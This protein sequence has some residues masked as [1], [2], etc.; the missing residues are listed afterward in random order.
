MSGGSC[1]AA[2]M[3]AAPSLRPQGL[4]IGRNRRSRMDA[5]LG[6]ADDHHRGL[7]LMRMPSMSSIVAPGSTGI[8]PPS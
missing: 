6:D 8:W 5:D 3:A 4:T 1:I 7:E 2:S